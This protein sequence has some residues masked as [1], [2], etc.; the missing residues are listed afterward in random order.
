MRSYK[1]EICKNV[2]C[3]GEFITAY[4]VRGL[5]FCSFNC[6]AEFRFKE[7]GREQNNLSSE[8]IEEEEEREEYILSNDDYEE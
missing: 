4:R 2:I 8:D 1:C 7:Y 3:E 5:Y 6:E